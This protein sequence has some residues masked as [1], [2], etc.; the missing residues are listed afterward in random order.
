MNMNAA[1][2]ALRGNLV[3]IERSSIHDGQGLRTVIFLKGCS[4]RCPWCST[5][6]SQ[7][8]EAEK[9]YDKNRC[10]AC[11]KC[12]HSCPAE[13]ISLSEDGLGV[14]T[15]RDKCRRCFQCAEVC[16][17]NAVKKYGYSNTVAQVLEEISKDEIFYYHSGGG[18]TLSGGEPLCQPEF[19]AQLLEE[20][21]KLGINTAMETSLQ[22]PYESLEASLPWLTHLYADL[23][24]MDDKA[25]KL[26]T[27]EGNSQILENILKADR[28]EFNFAITVRIPLIPGFNDSKANLLAVTE[29]CR[30]LKKIRTIELLPYHRLGSDTYRLLGLDYACTNVIP[31]TIAKMKELADLISSRGTGI[32]IGIGS[33][34]TLE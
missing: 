5:P 7:L 4:L 25:H 29:F 12:L 16:P 27:G 8:F 18:V 2:K 14:E 32:S 19:C 9:G 1:D 23:K 15:D 26:A 13:A 10:T 24:H 20:C 30:P 28:S 33:G 34:V 17:V 31:P 22:A 3:R 6:E 11:L 21:K